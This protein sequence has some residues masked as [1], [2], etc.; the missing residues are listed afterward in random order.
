VDLAAFAVGERRAVLFASDR[1]GAP[2]GYPMTVL[3]AD[4]TEVL[5][6]TYAKSAKVR[7]L[8][9]DPRAAVLLL[10]P[11]TPTGPLRWVSLQGRAV[12][13]APTP[14]QVEDLFARRGSDPRVPVAVLE[15][16]RRRLLDGKRVVI[17]VVVDS[18]SPGAAAAPGWVKR[19]ASKQTT[20]ARGDCS[21]V[22]ATALSLPAR[23][24]RMARLQ[25]ARSPRSLPPASANTV[26][27]L[28]HRLIERVG[29]I[30][31]ATIVFL[32]STLFGFGPLPSLL[33][34]AVEAV[35]G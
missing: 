17:T 28:N 22:P 12:V 26:L 35:I 4:A 9:A 13:S 7:H 14:A 21:P 27:V 34:D 31:V 6:T 30:L 15:R 2:I 29:T 3:A 18:A 19:S 10:A 20:A 11:P 33:D 5:F 23:E 25:R 16:T 24:R 32:G 1:R 8:A